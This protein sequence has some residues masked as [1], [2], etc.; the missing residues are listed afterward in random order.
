MRLLLNQQQQA[1]TSD[2]NV[3]TTSDNKRLQQPLPLHP[4]NTLVEAGVDVNHKA[5]LLDKLS[6]HL[7]LHLEL[8]EQDRK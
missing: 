7:G 1:T 2:N 4:I 5:A 6:K 8:V 3:A